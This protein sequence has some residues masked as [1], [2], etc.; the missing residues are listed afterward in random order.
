MLILK[1]DI[2]QNSIIDWVI[3]NMEQAIE[4]VIDKVNEQK[5][6]IRLGYNYAGF[7]MGTK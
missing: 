1:Y 7:E 3:F 5:Y 4:D 2:R 6:K